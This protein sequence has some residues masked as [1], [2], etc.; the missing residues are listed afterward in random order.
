MYGRPAVTLPD[1]LYTCAIRTGGWERFRNSTD[2]KTPF[3]SPRSAVSGTGLKKV[4]PDRYPSVIAVLSV[5]I[6]DPVSDP[7][8][9]VSKSPAS[10]ISVAIP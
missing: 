10:G 3:F 6:T 8:H 1:D 2:H 5:P 4:L 9:A 7:S